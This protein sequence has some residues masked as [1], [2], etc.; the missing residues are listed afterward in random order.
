QGGN[1][2]IGD[3]FVLIGAD[4]PART[5]DLIR[6]G[7]PILVPPGADPAAFVRDLYRQTFDPLREVM[8][9]GTPLAIPAAQQRTIRITGEPWPEVRYLGT[10]TAQPIFH[11]DMFITLAG[12][13][14]SGRY[15]LLVGSP[16]DADRILGR[17]PQPQGM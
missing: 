1:I 4:Y 14:A 5:L 9:A 11:I 16:S 10:G 7:A 13:G 2:L 6:Q 8:Y 12:R 3:D 17:P 15:R